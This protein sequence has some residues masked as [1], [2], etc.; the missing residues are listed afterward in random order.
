VTV[1]DARVQNVEPNLTPR[2]AIPKENTRNIH[3]L[4]AGSYYSGIM[5]IW[6]KLARGIC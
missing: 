2:V 1:C 4:N 5:S 6:T 3:A